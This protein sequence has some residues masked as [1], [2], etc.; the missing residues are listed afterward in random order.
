MNLEA[1]HGLTDIMK[2]EPKLRR[3][4]ACLS[5]TGVLDLRN[6]PTHLLLQWCFAKFQSGTYE[7]RLER[8]LSVLEQQLC[9]SEQR[10]HETNQLLLRS[11]D[12]LRLQR[13]DLAR[14][15]DELQ[16]RLSELHLAE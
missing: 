1:I 16:H 13:E 9:N 5:A 15:Q 3:H 4:A 8:R 10:R 7:N 11:E 12:E 14:R 2:G 6:L